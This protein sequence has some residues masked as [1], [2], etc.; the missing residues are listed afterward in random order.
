VAIVDCISERQWEERLNDPHLFVEGASVIMPL[1][2]TVS[3]FA[4]Q[5]YAD[6]WWSPDRRLVYYPSGFQRCADRIA[7][8][9]SFLA[10]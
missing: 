6:P 2:E 10:D 4:D 1:S 5:L 8:L 3:L 7:D 9:R